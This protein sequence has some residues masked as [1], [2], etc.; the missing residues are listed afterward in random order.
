MAVSPD[1]ELIYASPEWGQ[2]VFVIDA[3][4]GKKK[5]ELKSILRLRQMLF[6]PDGKSLFVWQFGNKVK[7]VDL[8]GKVLTEVEPREVLGNIT[9]SEKGEYL[10]LP[11]WSTQREIEQVLIYDTKKKKIIKKLDVSKDAIYEARMS[12]D[13]KTVVAA[14]KDEFLYFFPFKK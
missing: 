4:T 2:S 3:K 5:K 11:T 8:K 1:G 10:F 13:G 14:P 9:I 6:H 7:Q 12:P